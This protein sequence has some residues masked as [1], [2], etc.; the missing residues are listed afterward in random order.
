MTLFLILLISLDFRCFDRK[1]IFTI[2]AIKSVHIIVEKHDRTLYKPKYHF[3][4]SDTEA[5]DV[6][7]DKTDEIPSKRISGERKATSPSL[8]VS[9]S[10]YCGKR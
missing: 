2:I 4:E 10:G 5:V 8:I 6:F 9:T 1:L 7:S 3:P